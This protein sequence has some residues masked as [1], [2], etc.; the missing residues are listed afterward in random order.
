MGK[1][2]AIIFPEY[3]QA[4][5]QIDQNINSVAFLG[6]SG[7][8]SFT[9]MVPCENRSF[10]DLSLGNWNINSDWSLD[11]KYDL[12][13]CTRCAYFSNNPDQFIEKCKAYLNEAGFALIDWGLGDHW[14][15]KNF[16][17]GWIKDGEQE[18]AYNENNFLHSCYWSPDLERDENCIRFWHFCKK[19]GYTEDQT[20]TEVIRREVPQIVNYECFYVK[21]KFL[22][23]D[24]PQ[25][26][27]ITLVQK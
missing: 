4:L 22:W 17:V 12:I 2:D 8:N 18:Y 16:K 25:L 23:E 20:L 27:I 15:F 11:K 7:E 14:R 21:T 24:S 9:R 26:Y 19:R 3:V 5:S 13:V 1:S 6:F 10:Y